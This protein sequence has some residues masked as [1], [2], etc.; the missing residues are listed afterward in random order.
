MRISDWSS[1]V[2]SSDLPGS[3]HPGAHGAREGRVDIARHQSAHGKGKGD[4][5]ADIAEI[6][7][8]RM[9]SEAGVLPQ[10]SEPL[11]IRGRRLQ[12]LEWAG[13]REK[14]AR[15]SAV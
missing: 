11:Y 2:C 7:R 12:A 8:R 3:Q 9:E 4:R 6:Q 15:K 14:E 13:G 10:R 1:D 5:K